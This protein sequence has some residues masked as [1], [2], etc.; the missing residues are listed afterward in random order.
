MSSLII[1]NFTS[2]AFISSQPF[3]RDDA[4]IKNITRIHNNR[5]FLVTSSSGSIDSTA[6]KVLSQSGYPD[7]SIYR[8]ASTAVVSS[9]DG[10]WLQ[11]IELP[12]AVEK[13]N[14]HELYGE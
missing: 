9:H 12:G 8:I 2:M 6:I 4:L 14:H 1:P 10:I 13:T 11:R 5:T 7:A 3:S